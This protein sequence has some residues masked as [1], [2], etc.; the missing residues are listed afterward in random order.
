MGIRN[1]I[2]PATNLNRYNILHETRIF[3]QHCHCMPAIVQHHSRY[4]CVPLRYHGEKQEPKQYS[5][6]LVQAANVNGV[7]Q[8]EQALCEKMNLVLG[9]NNIVIKVG[10]DYFNVRLNGREVK[11]SISVDLDKL[12]EGSF[13]YLKSDGNCARFVL[14]G[15]YFTF[16]PGL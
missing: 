8:K 12:S 2:H 7:W 6:T 1:N 13:L 9:E 3:R 14:G 10:Q 4:V 5:S 11:E 16:K 15:S